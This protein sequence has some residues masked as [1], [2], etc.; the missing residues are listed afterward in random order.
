MIPNIE[1]AAGFG[2]PANIAAKIRNAPLWVRTQIARQKTAAPPAAPKPAT[3]RPVAAKRTAPRETLLIA[4][5]PGLSRPVKLAGGT[6]T[7]PEAISSR[8]WAGVMQQLADGPKVAIQ[9]GHGLGRPVVATTGSPNVRCHVCPTGGLFLSLDLHSGA[10]TGETWRGASIAFRPR[11]YRR[12][13]I[14]GRACR[15]IDAM[16]LSHVALIAADDPTEPSYGLARV[17]RCKP[18]ES[19]ARYLDLVCRTARAICKQTGLRAALR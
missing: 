9:R 7:L 6:E 11:R 18:S 13:T 8:A 14:D 1:Y 16:E 5:A 17:V 12:A 2:G 10:H 19:A 15:V 3:P 4:A